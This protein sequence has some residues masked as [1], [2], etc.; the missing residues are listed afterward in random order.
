M[1]PCA[2]Y[3]QLLKTLCIDTIEGKENILCDTFDRRSRLYDCLPKSFCK[4][5]EAM[6]SLLTEVREGRDLIHL[7]QIDRVRRANLLA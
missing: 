4:K 5:H 7:V 1:K 3:V 2:D 6:L